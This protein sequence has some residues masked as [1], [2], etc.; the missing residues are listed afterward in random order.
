M[1]YS[2]YISPLAFLFVCLSYAVLLGLLYI[3]VIA[4]M[5]L[6]MFKALQDA[7]IVTAALV[8]FAA[9]LAGK[10]LSAVV[11]YRMMHKQAGR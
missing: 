4:D 3:D 1:P 2:Q 11:L 9:A 8:L 10:M 6:V 7:E 5:N